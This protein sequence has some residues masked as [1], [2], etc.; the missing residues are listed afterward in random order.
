M[1]AVVFAPFII[2]GLLATLIGVLGAALIVVFFMLVDANF[3]RWVLFLTGA[4]IMLV[5]WLSG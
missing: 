1:L 4:T 5:R 2:S 3:A